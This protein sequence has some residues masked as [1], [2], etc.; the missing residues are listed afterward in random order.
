QAFW[1]KHSNSNS[2]TPVMSYT[3]VRIEA[4]SELSKLD[5]IKKTCVR[6]KEHSDSLISQI[7]TKSVANLY[8]NAQLQEKVF[9]IAALKNELRKLK[10]KNVVDTA[11]LTPIATTIAPG[12]F[13]LDIEPISHRLKN[14][15]DA[16]EEYLKKT[17][18]N[19]NTI[20]GL[21][22]RARIQNPN[23]PL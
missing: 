16:H 12:M 17:I 10:G 4:P 13:K 19:T 2:E 8:L 14:N 21:V 18:E 1:L 22:E 6:S 23:E 9:A 15:M 11:I 3:P 20:R 7:N 5:S